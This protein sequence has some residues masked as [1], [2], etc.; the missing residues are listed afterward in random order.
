M[1]FS[2]AKL[3][4]MI[5]ACHKLECEDSEL[6][7]EADEATSEIGQPALAA[8]KSNLEKRKHDLT[9]YFQK[10]AD[11]LFKAGAFS[12][13]AE[14]RR[15]ITIYDD[16]RRPHLGPDGVVPDDGT[17]NPDEEADGI[18]ALFDVKEYQF[19][20]PIAKYFSGPL[21]IAVN[22]DDFVAR[23]TSS[24]STLDDLGTKVPDVWKGLLSGD[25]S[26]AEQWIWVEGII[27]G[28]NYHNIR[29]QIEEF[30]VQLQGCML[31]LD[32]T[33]YRMNLASLPPPMT[34]GR[35]A[36]FNRGLYVN[37]RA[38]RMAPQLIYD[39]L[40]VPDGDLDQRRGQAAT[41]ERTWRLMKK[42]FGTN[43]IGAKEIRQSLRMFLRS[44]DSWNEGEKAMLLA[45]TLEGLLLD[46]KNKD[47]LSSRLQD[48][49]AFLLGG[50]RGMRAESRRI[51]RELYNARSAFV[52]N[53][54]ISPKDFDIEE[55]TKLTRGVL[56]KELTALA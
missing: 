48:S 12:S 52:H 41:L 55:A 29:I 16:D 17:L 6:D 1:D 43:Q 53:G 32:L 20:A 31:A 2:R 8:K 7:W 46:K 54:E 50:P 38:A 18:L 27:K 34:V 33:R 26:S 30:L 44:F 28:I 5:E 4:E 39:P 42:V 9:S 13:Q 10:L 25:L 40:L 51:V 47:D 14:A 21:E 24:F 15:A 3:I 45:T 23:I 37:S 49:V 19:Q 11:A 35:G 22:G 36:T 56:I